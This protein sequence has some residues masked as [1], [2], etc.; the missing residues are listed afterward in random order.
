VVPV[1]V[2]KEICPEP[3]LF[4]TVMVKFVC[5]AALG[6]EA[7]VTFMISL[8]LAGVESKFAPVIA[9]AVPGAAICGVNE[10]MRGAPEELVT[11][12]GLA[13]VTDAEGAV[14]VIAPVVAPVGTVT[15]SWV[16]EADVT[17]AVVPLNETASC[18]GSALKFA[19][20][21]VT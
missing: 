5:E 19:P 16:D 1:G 21:I 17:V 14:T 4:G 9:I 2:F 6:T 10:S 15:T 18:V 7:G 3:A 12:N 11:V 8:S 20:K 13:L